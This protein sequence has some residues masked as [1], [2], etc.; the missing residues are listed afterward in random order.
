MLHLVE[1]HSN[2]SLLGDF[3]VLLLEDVKHLLHLVEKC[4]E[5]HGAL[6]LIMERVANPFCRGD[7]TTGITLPA[8]MF[9]KSV[10]FDAWRM[11]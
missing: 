8:T 9:A 4:L 10:H 1:Q 5:G 2:F 11:V 3:F 6:I 7:P